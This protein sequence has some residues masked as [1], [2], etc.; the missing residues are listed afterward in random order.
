MIDPVCV[1]NKATMG[2]YAEISKVNP[3]E[4]Y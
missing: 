4:V 2:I 3:I 1:A